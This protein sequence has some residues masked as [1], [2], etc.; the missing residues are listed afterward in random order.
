MTVNN[1]VE[2]MSLEVLNLSDGEKT[3]T[4]GYT[5]DLLSWVMS[6]ASAGDAWITIMSNI[7]IIAVASL[8]DVSCI[9]LAENAEAEQSVVSLAAEKKINLLRSEKSSFAL[10]CELGR[11]L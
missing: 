11:L 6:R 3:V 1:L 2:K 4:G 5:G 7:N 8:C 10:S 9:I